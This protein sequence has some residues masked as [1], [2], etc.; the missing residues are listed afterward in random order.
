[1]ANEQTPI[2]L[3]TILRQV[4]PGRETVYDHQRMADGS[5]R[6]AVTLQQ[7][8]PAE[9]PERKL[10]RSAP[11]E[12]HFT[13]VE[14]LA[15]Y[16]IEYGDSRG[17]VVLVSGTGASVVL[18]ETAE[19]GRQQM[20][21]ALQLD[22]VWHE[23]QV[24]ISAGRVLTVDQ[25][26]LLV[27]RSRR[28]I[29]SPDPRTLLST[30]AAIEATKRVVVDEGSSARA[31]S[32]STSVTVKGKSTDVAQALP[33]TIKLATPIF[34]G[35]KTQ[36]ILV[37]LEFRVSDPT[38]EGAK[39]DVTVVIASSDAGAVFAAAEDELVASLR[40]MLTERLPQI[41]IGHGQINY[42]TWNLV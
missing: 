6:L 28:R 37:D 16:L 41:V 11:V 39:P 22:P 32:I 18:D 40:E 23:W 14:A 21:L 33:E 9:H 36:E 29:V 2:T 10:A 26:R 7:L 12:H 19:R 4:V 20:S 13:R 38:R 34:Q 31:L 35:G 24:V 1:M 42:G 17:V 27:L 8:P 30:L 5:G 15:A 25:L 3:D